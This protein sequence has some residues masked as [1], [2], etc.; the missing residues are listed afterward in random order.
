[1]IANFRHIL[2]ERHYL[3]QARWEYLVLK[4]FHKTLYRKE[5]P[6]TAQDLSVDF[7]ERAQLNSS[8][9]NVKTVKRTYTVA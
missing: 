9:V 7:S 4:M 2:G 8:L 3:L 5:K 1:M 6:I